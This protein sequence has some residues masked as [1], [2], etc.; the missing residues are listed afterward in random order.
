MADTRRTT[1]LLIAALRQIADTRVLPSRLRDSRPTSIHEVFGT[2]G[3]LE[4]RLTRR[5]L[6]S[7]PAE[8]SQ[9]LKKSRRQSNANRPVA[10]N[11]DHFWWR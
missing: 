6:E 5:P 3:L 1:P 8:D 2:A 7:G 4:P 10:Y 9:S 11:F